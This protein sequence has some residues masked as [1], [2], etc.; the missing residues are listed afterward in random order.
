MLRKKYKSLSVDTSVEGCTPVWAPGAD[1]EHPGGPATTMRVMTAGE[2]RDLG[3]AC[4]R[5]GHN[6]QTFLA[7]VS[8]SCELPGPLAALYTAEYFDEHNDLESH[9]YD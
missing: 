3:C 2:Q 7:V 1:A 9:M 8:C 5:V 6:P 4:E